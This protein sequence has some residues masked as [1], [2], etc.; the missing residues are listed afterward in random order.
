MGDKAGLVP[1]NFVEILP[2]SAAPT[3]IAKAKHLPPKEVCF[4]IGM[5]IPFYTFGYLDFPKA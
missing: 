1:D 4:K 2:A 5:H 3:P